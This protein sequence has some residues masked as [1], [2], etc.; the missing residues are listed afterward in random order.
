[1]KTTGWILIWGWI[2]SCSRE[3]LQSLWRLHRQHRDNPWEGELGT[4]PGKEGWSSQQ[5]PWQHRDNPWEGGWGSQQCPWQHRDNRGLGFRAMS[6]A[7]QGQSC[8][9]RNSPCEEQPSG[10]GTAL[11]LSPAGSC[12]RPWESLPWNSLGT[13]SQRLRG[14][15]CGC[16]RHQQIRGLLSMTVIS[17]ISGVSAVGTEPM[18]LQAAIPGSLNAFKQQ[19]G[20]SGGGDPRWV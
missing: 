15:I 16:G 14:D 6:L 10:D 1:M 4:V 2:G 7:A 17:E 18:F 9:C 20:G 12:L 5:C 3:A 11:E 8:S 13:Q 19:P